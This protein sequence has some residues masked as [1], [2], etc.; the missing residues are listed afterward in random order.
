MTAFR[1]MTN[2]AFDRIGPLVPAANI[3]AQLLSLQ[4]QSGDTDA[5][6]ACATAWLHAELQSVVDDMKLAR[7]DVNQ[8][9]REGFPAEVIRGTL[10][11]AVRHALETDHPG[12]LA[13]PR[14]IEHEVDRLI[15]EELFDRQL[16][17]GSVPIDQTVKPVLIPVRPFWALL[18]RWADEIEAS[19]EPQDAP[20]V[21]YRRVGIKMLDALFTAIAAEVVTLAQA[22]RATALPPDDLI[23]LVRNGYLTTDGDERTPRVRRGDF[24]TPRFQNIARQLRGGTV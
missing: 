18:A 19:A 12:T 20:Y 23:A 6:V 7:I 3:V 1:E 8:A 13:D 5:K 2:D 21:E 15:G 11:D 4:E 14:V 22:S 9:S 10:R 17:W 24:F 16:A